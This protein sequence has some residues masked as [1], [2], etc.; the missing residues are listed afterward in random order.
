MYLTDAPASYEEVNVTISEVSAHIGGEWHVVQQ[1]PATV[2]LLDW[3]NGEV[4]E[5]GTTDLPAGTYT[6]IR[7]KV[8]D[9]SVVENGVTHDM[10]VPSG[11]QTGLKL[12]KTFTIEE[13]VLF[14]MVLDFDA[15]RSV[16][17]TGPPSSP[18]GYMLQPTIRAEPLA[19]TGV[20]AGTVADPT[21]EPLAYAISAGDTVTTAVVDTA[22]GDFRLTFLP[23]QTYTVSVADTM[24]SSFEQSNVDVIAGETEAIGSVTLELSL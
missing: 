2:N 11:A 17:T 3:T 14:E 5:L 16:V 18:T 19:I 4:L 8:D 22:T 6:Q 1:T 7:L 24:G 9:A 15:H 20:I 13:D 10:T 23:P 12:N 21:H